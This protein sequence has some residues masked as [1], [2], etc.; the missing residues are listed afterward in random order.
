MS[1]A[2]K[3]I[4]PHTLRHSAAMALLHAGVDIA[5][6][7]LWLGHESI[8]STQA[9]L[10]ADLKLKE[11]ALARTTPGR[12]PRCGR[13]QPRRLLPGIPGKP[14][15]PVSRYPGTRSVTGPR[16]GRSSRHPE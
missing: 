10:H 7:A 5:V 8:Q 12:R 2:G 1:Q 6:I 9:Y 11:R 13:Y 15:T 14:M 16:T 4:S 3:K